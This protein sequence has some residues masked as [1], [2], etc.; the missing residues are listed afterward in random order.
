MDERELIHQRLIN[1]LQSMLIL[2]GMVALFALVGWL[3]GGAQVMLWTA[4]VGLFVLLLAPR[5]SPALMLRFYGARP[6]GAAD[7]PQLHSLLWELSGRAGLARAPALFYIADALP[8]AFSLGSRRDAVVVVTDGLL[9]DLSPRELSGA[10]AHEMSHIAHNDVWLMGLADQVSRMTGVLSLLGQ[11]LILLNLPLI[12]L[13]RGSVSWF[14]IALLILAPNISALLQMALSRSR[15]F[16]ADLGAADLTGDPA[17]LASALV[18]LEQDRGG[19]AAR[20]ILPSRRNRA[21]SIL[22]S[23][24]DTGERIRRLLTL[25]PSRAGASPLPPLGPFAEPPSHGP[26][27]HRPRRHWGGLWH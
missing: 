19:L 23:H 10:L 24:P 18:K 5:I 15:E 2:G 16:R 11:L 12:L 9:R 20:L 22:R 3:L 1:A 4:G 14:A 6:L 8:N 27:R 25:A 26:V 21:P 13:G 17:A 7:A